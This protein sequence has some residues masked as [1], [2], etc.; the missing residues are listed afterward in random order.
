M[1][2]QTRKTDLLENLNQSLLQGSAQDISRCVQNILRVSDD[3]ALIRDA[4]DILERR[5]FGNNAR[6]LSKFLFLLYDKIENAYMSRFYLQDCYEELLTQSAYLPLVKKYLNLSPRAIQGN[7]AVYNRDY[8]YHFEGQEKKYGVHSFSNEIGHNLTLL[9]TP[10]GSL[11]LDC[12]AKCVGGKHLSIRKNDLLAFLRVY[13]VA[14]EDILGVLISHAHL[15]HYGSISSL[16]AVGI[17]PFKFFADERTAKI[18]ENQCGESNAQSI[19]PISSFFVAN[20]KIQVHSY[21]NGHILG[22]QLFVIRFDDKTIV[23][24]G[25]FCLHDQQTVKGLRLLQLSEDVFV[26]DGVDCL[27]MEST[28]GNRIS[29]ILPY[30]DAER[31]L[32]T[33]I[34][35][36]IGQGYKVFLPALAVGRSQELTLM[37][38]RKY[39]LLIDGRSILLTQTYERL[40]KTKIM[41]S[42]VKYSTANNSKIDNFDFNDIIVAGSGMISGSSTSAQYIEGLLGSNQKVAIIRTGYKD[43]NEDSYEYSVFREWQK[44]GGLLFDIALSAHASY[45]ELFDLITTL[46]PQ[47]IVAV[48]GLGITHNAI[49]A[50]KSC[51]EVNLSEGKVSDDITINDPV[52]LNHWNKTVR[53]GLS[54]ISSGRSLNQSTAFQT[55]LGFLIKSIRNHAENEPLLTVMRSFDTIEEL[56]S[57]LR[58]AIRQ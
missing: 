36:L 51:C 34:D 50:D 3:D 24:T 4:I 21:D 44:Q 54:V 20:Q 57:F 19:R 38:S 9:I 16:I 27:I 43:S 33:M 17:S 23:Y 14:V 48:H 30:H 58:E 5:V 18:I 46:H 52:I 47:N 42:N 28:Y 49:P 41:I 11:I 37:L 7:Y 13:G 56:F 53:I 15:D 55:A 45:D 31:A 25:D 1:E 2:R 39:K 10:Y 32:L 22:S 40:L 12:G 35:K 6:Y 29:D 8:A 26:R